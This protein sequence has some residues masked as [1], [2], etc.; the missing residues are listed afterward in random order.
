AFSSD[1]R[2]LAV[3]SGRQVHLMDLATSNELPPLTGHQWAINAVMFSQDGTRLV[4]VS[5][6]TTGLVWD[7][8]SLLPPSPLVERSKADVRTIWE[9]LGDD[10][11]AV[12][13][14]A[15]WQLT[16]STPSAVARLRDPLKPVA[17]PAETKRIEALI[18]KLDS[19]EAETR[20][21]GYE[22]L[23]ELGAVADPA[24]TRALKSG[25]SLEIRRRLEELLARVSKLTQQRLQ[26]LRAI[27]ALER[28]AAPEARQLIKSLAE[29]EDGAWL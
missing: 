1:G 29:G 27:L 5:D 11:E 10:D 18:H 26:Q 8:A 19:D 25:P 4:S 12:A 20:K 6:D 22:D 17:A 2:I 7:G 15:A 23:E 14:R 9:N 16:N 21:S 24:L 28:A 13:Y 3:Q